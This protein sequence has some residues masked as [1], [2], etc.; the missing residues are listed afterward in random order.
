MRRDDLSLLLDFNSFSDT[1][2][3]LV[4]VLD[5][6]LQ[7]DRLVRPLHGVRHH[8]QQQGGHHQLQGVAEGPRGVD[9]HHIAGGQR[10]QALIV[11]VLVEL[12]D[13]VDTCI[14]CEGEQKHDES[15]HQLNNVWANEDLNAK[16]GIKEHIKIFEG[17]NWDSIEEE[18]EG[19]TSQW[20]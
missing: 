20:G 6:L 13:L 8:V 18:G 11:A 3:F 9:D 1:F 17:A 12:A 16:F 2:S 4:A 7:V 19:G 14:H 5:K 15:R 10:G